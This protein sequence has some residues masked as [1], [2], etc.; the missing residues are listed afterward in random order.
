MCASGDLAPLSHLALG[1]MGEVNPYSTHEIKLLTAKNLTGSNVE[2]RG[3]DPAC[4][5]GQQDAPRH[6]HCRVS[7]RAEALH[8]RCCETMA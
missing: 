6:L 2:P 7:I 1:M 8:G 3:R 4:G 5:T